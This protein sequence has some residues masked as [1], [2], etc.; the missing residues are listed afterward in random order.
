MR[1]E[2]LVRDLFAYAFEDAY[3]ESVL[4]PGN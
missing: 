4:D 1:S 2:P 3:L